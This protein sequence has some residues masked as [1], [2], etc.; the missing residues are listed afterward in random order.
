MVQNEIFSRRK[1]RIPRE[2]QLSDLSKVLAFGRFHGIS[3]LK[4]AEF[5]L[6]KA[7]LRRGI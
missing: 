7:I 1:A 2:N 4:S 3:P 6:I 5:R